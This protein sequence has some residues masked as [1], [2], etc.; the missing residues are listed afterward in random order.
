[1]LKKLQAKLPVLSEAEKN[2]QKELSGIREKLKKFASEI[3][4]VS[5]IMFVFFSKGNISYA[6]KTIVKLNT[7][8]PIC[9]FN[10]RY[11]LKCR[12]GSRNFETGGMPLEY[13]C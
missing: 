12:G 8:S 6:L 3:A 5:I 13:I 11:A 4:L 2:M 7:D 9:W 10:R 1:M